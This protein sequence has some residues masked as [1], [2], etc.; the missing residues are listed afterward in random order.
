MK[1]NDK[2][3]NKMNINKYDSRDRKKEILVKRSTPF[4]I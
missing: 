4:N 2:F 3:T 1:S